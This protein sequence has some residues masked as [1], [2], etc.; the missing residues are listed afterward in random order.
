MLEALNFII[1]VMHYLS[2]TAS[3]D[4]QLITPWFR[5]ITEKFLFKWW[6][7]L[8]SLETVMDHQ[9]IHKLS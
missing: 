1:F 4:G 8:E 9:T 7:N 2:E 6:N 5:L 3:E